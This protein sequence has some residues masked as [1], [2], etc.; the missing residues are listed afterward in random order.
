MTTKTLKDGWIELPR[1]RG[2]VLLQGG[3]SVRLRLLHSKTDLA[4]TLRE[5]EELL[6]QQ[7][8]AEQRDFFPIGQPLDSDLTGRF[9]YEMPIYPQKQEILH[10]L[11]GPCYTRRTDVHSSRVITEGNV[12]LPPSRPTKTR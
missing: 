8:A 9:V 4:T 2:A 3:I 1:T 10:W 7:L 5:A 6:D 12:E 11:E